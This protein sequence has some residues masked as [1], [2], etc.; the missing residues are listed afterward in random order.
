MTAGRGV[1]MDDYDVHIGKQALLSPLVGA[2]NSGTL[3]V[4]PDATDLV[5]EP[6]NYEVRTS[7]TGRDSFGVFK[8]V[9]T[10]MR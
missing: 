4:P 8:R 9:L 5:E 10:M 1:R 7:E 2:L 3:H 6:Q